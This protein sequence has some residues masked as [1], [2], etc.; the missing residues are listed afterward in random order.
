MRKHRPT[1]LNHS[2]TISCRKTDEKEKKPTTTTKTS[3]QIFRLLPQPLLFPSLCQC[4]SPIYQHLHA[5]KRWRVTRKETNHHLAKVCFPQL[6]P[7]TTPPVQINEAIYCRYWLSVRFRDKVHFS[8]INGTQTLSIFLQHPFG[9][10]VSA[11]A[12]AH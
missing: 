12:P 4:L 5:G 10:L 9:A 1:S 7:A 6:P 2:P 8:E 11:Q 3:R